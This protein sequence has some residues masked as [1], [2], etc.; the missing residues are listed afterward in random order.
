MFY[1]AIIDLH[2]NRIGR[3]EN[4]TTKIICVGRNYSA[5]AKELNNPIPSE[6]LLFI[7]STNSLLELE[8]N[9]SDKQSINIPKNQGECQHELEL[10]LLIGQPLTN[11]DQHQAIAAIEGVGLALDLTLRELQSKLKSKGQPWERAKSFDASCPVSGFI[12]KADFG[13]L[14]DID[15]SMTKNGQL[16]QEGNSSEM[17]FN[18]AFLICEISQ[19]FSLY[20]GD[21]ILTGTPEGVASLNSG[22]RISLQINGSIIANANIR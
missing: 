17:L 15:F 12:R 9:S 10:A 22:D 21:I 6:P 16:V 8:L 1:P 5:H 3:S 4:A 2:G 7:K 19:C 14:V 13:E 20:P 18:M 11:C